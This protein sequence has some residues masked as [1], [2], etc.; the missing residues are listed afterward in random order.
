MGRR[1]GARHACTVHPVIAVASTSATGPLADVCRSAGSASTAR[2]STSKSSC[3]RN[4]G[5]MRWKCRNTGA[6]PGRNCSAVMACAPPPTGMS[7]TGDGAHPPPGN[8]MAQTRRR[9]GR[10]GMP[11]TV[12]GSPAGSGW[13]PV[14]ESVQPRIETLRAGGRDPTAPR[15]RV[16]EAGRQ[17]GGQHPPRVRNRRVRLIAPIHT[18]P[19]QYTADAPRHCVEAGATSRAG[20]RLVSTWASGA[21][22]RPFAA[23]R[24][25]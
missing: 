4:S 8:A 24:S 9:A 7:V 16:E 21:S 19:A 15:P 18:N 6:R 1:D 5:G 23:Q 11:S 20:C 14:R 17:D 2:T 22:R 12:R 25:W 10:A 3:R 13:P